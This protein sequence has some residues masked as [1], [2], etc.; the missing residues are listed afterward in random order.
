MPVPLRKFNTSLNL[1]QQKFQGSHL[2]YNIVVECEQYRSDP[3][4]C[5]TESTGIGEIYIQEALP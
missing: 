1:S 3:K 5:A 2:C 4:G